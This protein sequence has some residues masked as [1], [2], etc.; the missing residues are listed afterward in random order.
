MILLF[1]QSNP[2]KYKSYGVFLLAKMRLSKNSKQACLKLVQ[3]EAGWNEGKRMDGCY[4]W[5]LSVYFNKGLILWIWIV[6]LS[7][8]NIQSFVCCWTV[9]YMGLNI[10]NSYESNSCFPSGY[11]SDAYDLSI[12]YSGNCFFN[13]CNWK[14]S[15]PTQ[16]Q[17]QQ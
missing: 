16:F 14:R 11:Y 17:L 2:S 1:V 15:F 4:L 10:V 6:A 7:H 13:S 5:Y 3:S 12:C 9:S 8:N